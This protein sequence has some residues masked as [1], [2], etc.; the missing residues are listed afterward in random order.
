MAA[1]VQ[2]AEA[3]KPGA[4]WSNQCVPLFRRFPEKPGRPGGKRLLGRRTSIS[5]GPATTEQGSLRAHLAELVA[6]PP[7]VAHFFHGFVGAKGQRAA[8]LGG[9]A[10]V[11]SVHWEDAATT[12][13]VQ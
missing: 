11:G 9:P 12:P 7:I 8:G 4:R 1:I 2:Q 6:G 3:Q 5:P 10:I 13:G